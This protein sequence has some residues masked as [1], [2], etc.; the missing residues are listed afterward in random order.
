MLPPHADASENDLNITTVSVKPFARQKPGPTGLQMKATEFMQAG[1]VEAFVQSIFNAMRGSVNGDFSKCTLVVGGNG[2]DSNNQ[3]M[4][5]IL[6]IAIGN[7]FGRLLVARRGILSTA[8][9]SAVIRSRK[10]FGGLIVSASHDA[11]GADADLRIQY[12]ASNGEAAP[13]GTAERIY[14]FAQHIN[15]YYWFQGDDIEINTVGTQTCA[16]TE[17][18]VFDPQG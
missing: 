1:Y 3:A 6:H 9:M 15:H 17:I 5:K 8:A 14:E 10:A 4:Q 12:N 18:E 11:G 16:L 13:E 7:E 2:H